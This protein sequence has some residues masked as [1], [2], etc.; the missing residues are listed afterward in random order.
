MQSVRKIAP[1]S[2]LVWLLPVSSSTSLGA[3]SSNGGK[4]LYNRLLTD[5]HVGTSSPH[6]TSN[7]DTRPQSS[8]RILF[9]NFPKLYKEFNVFASNNTPGMKMYCKFGICSG[10]ID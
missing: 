6:S 9:S 1:S 4:S 10:V 7:R 2:E 8:I 3:T 5:R